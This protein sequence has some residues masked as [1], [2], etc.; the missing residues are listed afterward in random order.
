MGRIFNKI[1]STVVVD[2]FVDTQCGFKAFSRGTGVSLFEAMRI[3]HFAFDVE[4][5]FL[6]KKRG[7]KILELPVEWHNSEDSR[8]RIVQDSSKMLRDAFRIR[9]ND[10]MGRYDPPA[11]PGA[12]V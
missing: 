10:L 11:R 2:G 4:M 1:I 12:K 3:D 9:C 6:A 7:L 5:L 8:V